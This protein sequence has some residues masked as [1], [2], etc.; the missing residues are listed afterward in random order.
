MYSKSVC[1]SFRELH[2]STPRR[3]VATRS[4]PR[5]CV[6]TKSTPGRCVATIAW[7]V[8]IYFGVSLSVYGQEATTPIQFANKVAPILQEHCVACHGAK[9][10]E[11][12]YRI[13]SIQQ[14]F[15]AG[16]SGDLPIVASNSAAS[17][18]LVRICASDEAI[19]MPAESEPL[20]S[21]DRDTI[22]RW[23]DEGAIVDGIPANEPLWSVIP[24][25]TNVASP[26]HY[27][28]PPLVSALV[29]SDDGTK[30]LSSGYREVLVWN[31]SDG[32]LAQRI[33]NQSERI[34]A[35]VKLPNNKIAVA[36]GKPG[37]S[38]DV[39]IVD[40]ATSNIEK[41][42]ARSSDVVLDIALRPGKN[43]MAVAIADST[44]RLIDLETWTQRRQIASHADWV[45]QIAFNDD[46]TR[47]GSA[48]RDKSAKIYD[49]ESGDLLASYAGHAAA[50]RGI[51]A[52]PGVSQWMSVGS[53]KKWHRW[54]VEGAKKVAEVA[55]GGETNK[56]LR[57]DNCILMPSADKHWYR[58]D[59]SNNTIALKQAGHADWVIS[60][61]YHAGTSRVATGG[62]DGTIRIWNWA[63]GAPVQSWLA[64]P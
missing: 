56:L 60:T 59:L 30:L 61:A 33:P 51:A 64:K 6:A 37:A 19:R 11:G 24:P 7:C 15:K 58:L 12:G 40:V 39:R 10:A 44:I 42:V 17:Q 3:C 25:V 8:A 49:V 18:V 38:G 14:L 31:T 43:E 55:V 52:V 47:L 48:S 4:T 2:E 45:M 36:G 63:D 57:V 23:I 13:D 1:G 32:T 5:R 50:V 27:P 62:M 34:Q 22:K 26:A 53:D 16:E 54:E 29:F 46:G 41:I 21:E 20:K 9:R 35:M 28:S